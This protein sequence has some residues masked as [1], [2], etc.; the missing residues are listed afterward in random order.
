M[1]PPPPA[2]GHEVSSSSMRWQQAAERLFWT[3]VSAGG[4]SLATGPLF[5]VTVWQSAGVA[6]ASAVV[7]G[8]TLIARQRLSVLPDPGEGLPGLE[9]DP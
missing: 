3:A 8:I 5:G 7:N 2:D 9:V 4:A 1:T 6:A